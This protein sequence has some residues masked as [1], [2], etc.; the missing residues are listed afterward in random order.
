MKRL[1]VL[2]LAVFVVASVPSCAAIY[3]NLPKATAYAQ[4]A[5]LVVGAVETFEHAYFAVNPNPPLEKTIDTAIARARAAIDG[6]LRTINGTGAL[7]TADLDTAFDEFRV[8]YGDLINLVKP[9]GISTSG[10]GI[11][12]ERG[13]L[14]VPEPMAMSFHRR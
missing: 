11:K 14:T 3:S 2:F 8:A 12:A 5:A 7:Q 10:A 9:L 1:S 13:G 6:A 4:D